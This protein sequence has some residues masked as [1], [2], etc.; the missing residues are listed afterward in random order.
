MSQRSAREAASGK[1]GTKGSRRARGD[2]GIVLMFDKIK[3]E[4]G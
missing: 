1:K 2:G 4:I 3:N